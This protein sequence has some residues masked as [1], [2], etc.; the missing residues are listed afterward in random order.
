M[1]FDAWWSNNS[2]RQIVR[3]MCLDAYIEGGKNQLIDVI[4][5]RIEHE[6][7]VPQPDMY[8]RLDQT[9]IPVLVDILSRD[10][11]AMANKRIICVHE[12]LNEEGICRSCGTD[13]RGI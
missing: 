10:F 12:R 11:V 5:I 2:A 13:R 6:L 4:K 1:K 8:E 9:E 3:N 7:G